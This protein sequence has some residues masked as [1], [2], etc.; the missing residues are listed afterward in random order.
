MFTD[1]SEISGLKGILTGVFVFVYL[2][3][4]VCVG[5][6]TIIT[7]RLLGYMFEGVCVCFRAPTCVYK[8]NL[9]IC[10][11]R[12]SC[13]MCKISSFLRE[14]EGC[15]TFVNSASNNTGLTLTFVFLGF[16]FQTFS[17]KIF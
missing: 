11:M 4:R 5:L 9:H 1:S 15:Q 8:S 10:T 2:C 17:F 7:Y 13:K 14:P 6:C 3:L 12:T 16:H